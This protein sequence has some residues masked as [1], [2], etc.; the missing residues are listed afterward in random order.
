MEDLCWAPQGPSFPADAF[1]AVCLCRCTVLTIAHRLHTIIDSDR[2]MLLDGGR[3]AEF[4]TPAT[5]L[6]DRTSLFSGF[7]DQT[8]PQQAAALR[9]AALS[10][11]NLAELA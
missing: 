6:A 9:R 1:S 7:V 10:R 5:L 2:V 11:S 4:D 3:L 8:L